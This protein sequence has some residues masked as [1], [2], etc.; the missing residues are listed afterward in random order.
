MSSKKPEVV[1]G[2]DESQDS[3][4]HPIYD[5]MVRGSLGAV[6]RNGAST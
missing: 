2:A 6:V 5:E 3:G 4:P 1:T